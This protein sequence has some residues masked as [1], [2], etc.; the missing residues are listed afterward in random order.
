MEFSNRRLEANSL[1]TIQQISYD[2]LNK[3]YLTVSVISYT[4][5]WVI[6]VSAVLIASFFDEQ[7]RPVWVNLTIAAVLF[8][9]IVASYVLTILG[10]RRK[11]YAVREK[12]I[13]YKKGLLWRS[14]VI[15]PFNRI[16][17]AEVHQGPLDRLFGLSNLKIY[18]AGGSS[19]DLSIPGLSPE[20]A[21]RI[22]HF[23]MRKT[24]LDEEE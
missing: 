17:H 7:G 21:Q 12:D 6:I 23:V 10:F 24:T 14:S 3:E 9:L 22:K 2:G 1:P 20:T 5:F 4:I 13:I 8:F 16:Q 18:T 19:S 11:L 15:I